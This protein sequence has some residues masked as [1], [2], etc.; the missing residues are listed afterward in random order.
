MKF[1][2]YIFFFYSLCIS[3]TMFPAH[4]SYAHK[5]QCQD[6]Y[7]MKA[8]SKNQDTTHDENDE[9]E[10]AKMVQNKMNEKKGKDDDDNDDE[11]RSLSKE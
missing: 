6:A 2:M 10:R 1:S 11:K 7:Y 8:R 5:N 3:K 9:K 4:V